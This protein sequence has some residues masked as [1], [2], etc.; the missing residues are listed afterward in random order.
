MQVAYP[1][2][3]MTTSR[4]HFRRAAKRCCLL[5]NGAD[6]FVARPVVRLKRGGNKM[7]FKTAKKF[8]DFCVQHE[9][10]E[11]GLAEIKGLTLADW[12]D[13]TKRGDY[14]LWLRK[15]GVWTFPEPINA[16]Y[17]SYRAPIDAKYLADRAHIHAKY[18]ADR[19]HIHAKYE[20]DRAPIY[21]KY[22]AALAP[23]DAKYLAARAPIHAKYEA[24]RAPIYAK[25]EAALAPI[26][27]KY[28]ADRAPID[29]KYEAA[30]AT[31]IRSLVGNPF[32]EV[33]P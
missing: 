16:K 25:Y 32:R 14:M 3:G 17:E 8:Y 11:E 15:K 4:P 9:A 20:A 10:C 33:K 12:W 19:A 26:Y 28:L 31:L 29:A 18:L 22:E 13:K 24:A 30:R 1:W 23:I 21:A 7:I 2:N 6:E 27:A 5:Q